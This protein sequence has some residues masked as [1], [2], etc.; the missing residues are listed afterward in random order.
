[1]A[2]VLEW[3]RIVSSCGRSFIFTFASV[4]SMTRARLVPRISLLC[5]L[6]ESRVHSERLA[7][8]VI[9]RRWKWNSSWLW[10]MTKCANKALVFPINRTWMRSQA[11][12]LVLRMT[13]DYAP[14]SSYRRF[15]LSLI[16][17]S[18]LTRWI[19][20][21]ESRLVFL[22]LPYYLDS[23]VFRPA[24]CLR[25]VRLNWLPISIRFISF[26]SFIFW[27][28]FFFFFFVEI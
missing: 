25:Y 22:Q 12:Q 17:S 11:F 21:N 20:T 19:V 1:M 26:I 14:V 7:W 4:Q 5:R 27:V 3:I 24:P 15:C 10:K 9:S 8:L 13:T 18:W 23:S 2:K 16:N 28:I 6:F